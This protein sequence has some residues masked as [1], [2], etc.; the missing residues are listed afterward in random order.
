MREIE[1]ISQSTYLSFVQLDKNHLKMWKKRLGLESLERTNTISLDRLVENTVR[2][3]EQHRITFERLEYLLSLSGLQAGQV[4]IKS[5]E[6]PQ[7]PSNEELSS[8]MEI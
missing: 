8:L 4:G 2:A 7:L 5:P 6:Q 1:A 3:Y